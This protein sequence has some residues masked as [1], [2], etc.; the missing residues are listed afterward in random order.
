MPINTSGQLTD[1]FSIAE[2]T[3]S[4]TAN[5]KG[6][7][8]SANAS[9]QNNLIR[10]CQTLEQVRALLGSRSIRINSG[11]R[12]DALNRA[13]G[14]STTSAHSFGLAADFVCPGF[15]SPLAIC[16][17]IAASDIMFDQLIWEG[18]WVHIGLATA[19]A[20]PRRQVLTA[21]FS[22]GKSTTYTPGL[23]A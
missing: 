6:I 20:K 5:E 3:F 8:N 2:M 22:P 16:R 9:I 12:C 10:T 15:G 1:H 23:P 7:D 13:V 17:K 18:S 11:Y 14:G 21:H 4:P 19:D